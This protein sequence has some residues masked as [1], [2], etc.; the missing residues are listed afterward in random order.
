MTSALAPCAPPPATISAADMADFLDEKRKEIQARYSGSFLGL[1]WSYVQ[2]AVRFGMYFFVMGII[3]KLHKTVP[4]FGVHMFAGM[5]GTAS[6]GLFATGAFGLPTPNGSD[7]SSVVT[8]LFYG[9]GGHLLWTQVYG[10]FSVM[11][12]VFAVAIALMYAVKATGTLRV[13]RQGEE[14]GLDLHEHGVDAYP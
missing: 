5:T 14:E 4:V 8:G 3:L 11:L 12:A 1:F 10:T 6:L 9:G 7:T 2:P 13:S